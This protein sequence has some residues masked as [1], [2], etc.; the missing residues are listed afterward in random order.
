MTLIRVQNLMSNEL[1][2]RVFLSR[3][4]EPPHEFLLS[5]PTNSIFIGITK[6]FESPF[7][8]TFSNLTNPHL[9]VVGITGAGK[10][11]FVK[12]FLIRASYIWNTNA[13][14]IDWAGEYK[15]WVKQSGGTVVSLAKGDYL[16]IMDL[17][18]MRPLDRAKQIINSFE[19]L[20]DISQYPEQRRLTM[21]AVEQS[22]VNMGFTLAGIPDPHKEAPTLKN[23]ISLL[24]EKLQEGTYAYPAELENAIYRLRQFAREGED[25][26]ARKSTL[27]L[28]K[29]VS[30]G[31]VALDLSGLPDESFRALAA[32]FILQSLKEKMRMEGWSATKGLKAIIVLDEAWKVASDERSDAVM[33]V[34]EGRKYQFG[35][36]V[37][38]Q[39][40]TD[41][42]EAIFSNVGTTIMLRIKFE[43]FM[44]YLQGSLNFSDFMRREISKFGVG[45]AAIDMSFQT[46]VQFPEVFLIE[47]VVGEI[48]L[49]VYT[50]S[51]GDILNQDELERA[52]IQKEYYFEKIDL[53][54]KLIESNI[55]LEQIE[56]VFKRLDDRNRQI[57]IRG[58][59][60][61]FME[62]K[63]SKENTIQFLRSMGLQDMVITRVF[64][65]VGA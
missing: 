43:K 49:D 51:V 62:M 40:P 34:R 56:G 29:L 5:D 32:L 2:K 54:S 7:T 1:A 20:T 12:T 38:S 15:A 52:D 65:F 53:R 25:Y 11:F 61:V 64:T 58:F 35:L 31:L 10:S 26:F 28:G 3:P 17:S 19:I 36:I 48:P 21:E 27:D 8:W 9:A 63:V 24:E 23:V 33:I 16:N 55:G 45:Q 46:S 18:G 6:I 39:N 60:E 22:Y 30:S 4:P 13:I 42:N 47:R 59:V 14:I 57:D 41:I 50:I 37:A 44:N